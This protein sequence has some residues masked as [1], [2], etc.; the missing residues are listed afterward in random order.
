MASAPPIITPK[1]SHGRLYEADPERHEIIKTELA[2]HTQYQQIECFVNA[3]GRF[4]AEHDVNEIFHQLSRSRT[5]SRSN[6]YL[7]RKFGPAWQDMG[8]WIYDTHGDASYNESTK[9]GKRI[10]GIGRPIDWLALIVLGSVEE[11][12]DGET[13]RDQGYHMPKKMEKCWRALKLEWVLTKQKPPKYWKE[14][15]WD[16]ET[17]RAINC[18][19]NFHKQSS[20]PLRSGIDLNEIFGNASE[21]NVPVRQYDDDQNDTAIASHETI[22]HNPDTNIGDPSDVPDKTS[23]ALDNSLKVPKNPSSSEEATHSTT[24]ENVNEQRLKQVEWVTGNLDTMLQNHDSRMELLNNRVEALLTTHATKTEVNNAKDDIV[25]DR[26]KRRTEEREAM[27]KDFKTCVDNMNIRD[28][29]I[30]QLIEQQQRMVI[31]HQKLMTASKVVM[32]D[33]TVQTDQPPLTE[34]Q[35]EKPNETN[36]T[37]TSPPPS[38]TKNQKRREREKRKREELKKEVVEKRQKT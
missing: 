19:D 5:W 15:N 8:D 13:I 9:R 26:R 3:F 25:V 27:R 33:A 11:D 28:D 38:K 7:W 22:I 2:K 32:A 24:E 4:H 12:V 6:H 35:Q 23:N 1:M 30:R 16:D 37:A 31:E 20:A 21:Y 14:A 17:W 29:T 10:P 18:P 34:D 36:Q